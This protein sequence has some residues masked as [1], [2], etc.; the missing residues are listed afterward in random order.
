MYKTMVSAMDKSIG[1]ILDTLERL[2]FERNTLV[3][4]A[5]DNGSEAD[6]G[7]TG[8]YMERKVVIIG[9]KGACSRHLAMGR[10]SFSCHFR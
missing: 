4:F 5:S 7:H 10:K 3:I 8:P 2:D 1:K 9:R 6:A